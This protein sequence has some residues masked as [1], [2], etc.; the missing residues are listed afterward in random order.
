[1]SLYLNKTR[2]GHGTYPSHMLLLESPGPKFCVETESSTR[3]HLYRKFRLEVK[4]V[5][6]LI[7]CTPINV[8]FP[9]SVYRLLSREHPVV[10]VVIK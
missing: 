4:E 1:M 5:H 8:P 9:A 6:F 2:F 10:F 3:L 7:N